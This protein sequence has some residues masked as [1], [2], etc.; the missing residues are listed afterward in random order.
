MMRGQH[1]ARRKLDGLQPHQAERGISAQ[2]PNI[3]GI[4]EQA[5]RLQ[6]KINDWDVLVATP[7]LWWLFEMEERVSNRNGGEKI[8]VGAGGQLI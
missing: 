5:A 2:I 7:A 1:Q 8:L 6:S 4:G 3:K